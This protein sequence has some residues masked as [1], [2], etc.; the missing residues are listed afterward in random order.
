MAACISVLC[1]THVPTYV[2]SL[3]PEALGRLFP[4]WAY[5]AYVCFYYHYE[6]Q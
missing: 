3:Y 5:V 1:E 4:P 2:R 6:P